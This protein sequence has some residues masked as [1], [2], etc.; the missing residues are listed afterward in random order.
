LW[1]KFCTVRVATA[2][3]FLPLRTPLTGV[4][5]SFSPPQTEYRIHN[6]EVLFREDATVDDL[7]DVI[8]GAPS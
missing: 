1:T 2:H 6:A 4:V 5:V 7:I 3:L 8:E